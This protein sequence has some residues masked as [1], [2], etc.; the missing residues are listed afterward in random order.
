MKLQQIQEASYYKK[1][2][3]KEVY[4]RLIALRDAS[5]HYADTGDVQILEV[6]HDN[7]SV[8]ADTRVWTYT[9]DDVYKEIDKIMKKYDI[10]YT[11][12]VDVNNLA[13]HDWR[14]VIVCGDWYE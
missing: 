12:V 11:N 8:Y 3:P 4:D 7:D 14:A 6:S 5:P 9:E 2:S 13:G 1:K 10:P